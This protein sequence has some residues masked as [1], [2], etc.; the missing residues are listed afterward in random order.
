MYC[1]YVFCMYINTTD[2]SDA[3]A[4]S[5]SSHV[6]SC[7]TRI[8]HFELFVQRGALVIFQTDADRGPKQSKETLERHFTPSL[9]HYGSTAM[10][11]PPSVTWEN[12]GF[13][14]VCQFILTWHTGVWQLWKS[15]KSFGDHQAKPPPRIDRSRAGF[16]LRLVHWNVGFLVKI[17]FRYLLGPHRAW[18]RIRE[19]EK[20]Q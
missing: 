7:V 19:N 1:V 13:R 12:G 6:H 16:V 14:S 3:R 20:K 10:Q 2:R 18:Q 17:V 8:G 5:S 11:I 4:P 15:S 9:H